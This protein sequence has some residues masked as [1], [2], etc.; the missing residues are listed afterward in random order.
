MFDYN[1]IRFQG[2]I[3]DAMLQKNGTYL[4]PNFIQMNLL[5]LKDEKSIM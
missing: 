4:N 5:A 2:Y 1:I 3:Y